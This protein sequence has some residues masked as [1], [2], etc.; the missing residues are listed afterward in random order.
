MKEY[1]GTPT[2]CCLIMDMALDED[3]LLPTITFS[4]DGLKVLPPHIAGPRLTEHGRKTKNGL[5]I[6]FCP[7]C[8]ANLVAAE[9]ANAV[10]VEAAQS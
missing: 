3:Y 1:T 4:N 8:G 2:N 6:R 9:S 10:N 5:I 7:F